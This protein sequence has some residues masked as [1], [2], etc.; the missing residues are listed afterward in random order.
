MACLLAF[1]WPGHIRQL[2]QVLAGALLRT[3]DGV[4]RPE[5]LPPMLR[6][7]TPRPSPTPSLAALLAAQERE[8]SVATWHRAGGVQARAARLLGISERSLWSRL[9][10]L[11][12][13][14][15]GVKVMS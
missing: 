9:N 5:H 6:Q 13:D 3:E 15:A 4:M 11:D 8:H 12:I 2:Q 7:S 1:A 14:P 10:K